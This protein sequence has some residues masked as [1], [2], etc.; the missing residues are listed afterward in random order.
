MSGLSGYY[1]GNK[2]APPFYVYVQGTS[3]KLGS[4]IPPLATDVPS[5]SLTLVN[6]GDYSSSSTS[7]IQ[8]YL[9]ISLFT[10]DQ[11]PLVQGTVPNSV[12]QID[13]AT[14]SMSSLGPLYADS[15]FVDS[16]GIVHLSISQKQQGG[17]GK[18]PPSS[19]LSFW[20][21]YKNYIIVAAGLVALLL[22]VYGIRRLRK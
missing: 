4:T 8:T 10:A 12:I 17:G 13:G 3:T 1:V 18:T 5:T 2:D 14:S 15:M 7:A 11:A 21:K 20:T 9:N 19:P 6:P 16:F 22:V